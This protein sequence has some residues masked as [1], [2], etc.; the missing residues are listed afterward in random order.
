MLQSGVAAGSGRTTSRPLASHVALTAQACRPRTS[1]PNVSAPMRVWS[2]SL[3]TNGLH[4]VGN[5]VANGEYD[6]SGTSVFSGFERASA[7]A[8]V[9]VRRS[10]ALVAYG[11]E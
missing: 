7:G 5:K 8:G 11:A 9:K 10:A 6:A 1:L 3:N 2:E 4:D